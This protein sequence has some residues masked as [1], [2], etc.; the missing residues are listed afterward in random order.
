M[1]AV[2]R[3]YLSEAFTFLFPRRAN[4]DLIR[5]LQIASWFP[6]T[7]KSESQFFWPGTIP[8]LFF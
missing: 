8:A 3:C 4:L 7:L 2:L 6:G 1:W 5:R